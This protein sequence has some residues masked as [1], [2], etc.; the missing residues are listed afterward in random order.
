MYRYGIGRYKGWKV[1]LVLFIYILCLIIDLLC[2][3][4]NGIV[5]VLVFSRVNIFFMII[6]YVLFKLFDCYSI[7][8]IKDRNWWCLIFGIYFLVYYIVFFVIGM[9]W[10]EGGLVIM[11]DLNWDYCLIKI[12]LFYFCVFFLEFCCLFIVEIVIF[13]YM[14]I[15]KCL[16]YW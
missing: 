8:I 9:G 4:V 11:L 13:S 6:L 7:W 2:N 1:L 3:Y 12:C 10:G 16:I 15:I 5:G 14:I